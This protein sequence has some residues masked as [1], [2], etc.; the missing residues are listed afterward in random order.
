MS[1]A[2]PWAAILV[3]A[4]D[5]DEDDDDDREDNIDAFDAAVVAL[6]NKEDVEDKDE[7]REMLCTSSSM[8]L[9]TAEETKAG[10]LASLESKPVSRD[11]MQT[12]SW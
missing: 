8:P 2:D 5:D 3:D 10:E 12:A 4:A 6:L 9:A 1:K 7:E 11:A